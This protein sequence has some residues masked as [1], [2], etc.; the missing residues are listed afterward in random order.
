MLKSAILSDTST[1]PC[2][3]MDQID[4]ALDLIKRL[5]PTKITENLES[6]KI[7]NPEITEELSSAVDKPLQSK[8]CPQ[9]AKEYLICDYNKDGESYRY[10]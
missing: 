6:I 1:I 3:K 8:I 2:L 5:D 9:T 10:I 7:L 4:H